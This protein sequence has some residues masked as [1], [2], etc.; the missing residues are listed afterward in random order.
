MI[1]ETDFSR[2]VIRKKEIYVANGIKYS[3]KDIG[4][5]TQGELYFFSVW[6]QQLGTCH[7]PVQIMRSTLLLRLSVPFRSTADRLPPAHT[8]RTTCSANLLIG[9]VISSRNSPQTFPE[10]YFKK[11]L[12]T[13]WPSLVD[14]KL[15]I[16]LSHIHPSTAFPLGRLW[17]PQEKV[18]L[19][20]WGQLKISPSFEVF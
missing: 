12:D 7:V 1:M 10:L 2:P 20:S 11:C 15:T 13:L 5:E 6:A 17:F 19:L 14:T 4:L 9:T 16:T 3:A 18:F 8:E